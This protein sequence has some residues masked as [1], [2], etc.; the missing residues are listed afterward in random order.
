MKLFR[1]SILFL[2]LTLFAPKAF[3]YTVWNNTGSDTDFG[4]AANWSNGIPT[5]GVETF[6]LPGF[7]SDS[8]NLITSGGPTAITINSSSNQAVGILA[9]EGD[10]DGTTFG[11][12]TLNFT[13]GS[14]LTATSDIF[15]N[16][17][18]S[19]TFNGNLTAQ[20][21]LNEIGDSFGPGS[22]TLGTGLS[23][24]D[25]QTTSLVIGNAGTGSVTQTT[26]SI[27]YAGA[28]LTIGSGG[29]NGTYSV[30]NG[31]ILDLGTPGAPLSTLYNVSVG[32]STSTGTLIISGSSQIVGTNPG[33]SVNVGSK[34]TVTQSDTSVVTIG[35]DANANSSSLV[36][37][38]TYQLMGAAGTNAGGGTLNLNH[39]V[40]TVGG[41]NGLLSQTGNDSVL[42]VDAASTLTLGTNGKG[43]YTL[44]A[45]VAHF[46]GL[47]AIGGP[48]SS[49]TGVLNQSG[50][51]ALTAD[52]AVAIGGTVG[53]G[54]GIYTLGGTSATTATFSKG[55]T[56]AATGILNL[57]GGDLILGNTYSLKVNAG[58]TVNQ[59]AGTFSIDSTHTLNLTAAGSTYNLTGGIL[60]TS[61][62]GIVGT[63]GKLNFGG[64]TLQVVGT[65]FTDGV[66]G[67]LS[68]STPTLI[69]AS[70][71]TVTSVVMAGS[72]DG[73]GGIT[74]LGTDGTN[75][76]PNTAF[77]FGGTNSYTGPTTISSGTLNAASA[78]IQDS[79]ALNIGAAGTLNLNLTGGFTYDGNVAGTSSVTTGQFHVTFANTGDTFEIDGLNN[80]FLGTTTLTGGGIVEVSNGTF[81]AING[82]SSSLIIGDSGVAPSGVVNIGATSGITSTQ[83]NSQ[84][85][86][87]AVNLTGNVTN[88]G[89]L[90]VAN[91]IGGNVTNN[92]GSLFASGVGN[93][94][95]LNSGTLGSAAPLPMVKNTASFT[96]GGALNSS[97]TIIIR[98][99]GAVADEFTATTNSDVSGTFFK[100]VNASG[101][102]QYTIVDDTG[103]LTAT[104][105]TTNAPTSLF[106]ATVTKVGNTVVLN[107]TQLGL[108][109]FAV[110]PNQKAV[111]G[112]LDPLIQ[113]PAPNLAP[114]VATLNTLNPDQIASVLTLL[115][116]ESLQYARNISFENAT[117]LAEQ[118]SGHLANIRDGY[119]G[120]DTSGLSIRTV[121]L[122]SALGQSL[123]SLLAY[124]GPSFNR[125]APNGVNYYPQDEFGTPSS[126]SGGSI[127]DS[128]NPIMVPT[129]S[130]ANSSY[131]AQ[132]PSPS[133]FQGPYFSEF[134]AGNFIL[135]DLNQNQSSPNAAPSKASYTAGSATAGVSFRMTSNLAAGVLFDYNHT[136]A[137]TD[138]HGSKTTVNTYSPG[139]FAT[140]FEKGFYVD[141][142]FSFGYNNYKND[143]DVGALG[144]A[145]SSPSGEQYVTNV[146]FGYDFHPNPHWTF[147]PTLGMTYTHLDIDSFTETGVDPLNLSVASQSVDSLRSRLGGRVVYQVRS[148]TILF[149]PNFSAMWQHEY[150]NTNSGITSQFNGVGSSPFTIQTATNGKDSALLGCGVTA[151]LDNSLAFYLNYMADVGASDYYAQ[152]VEGGIKAQF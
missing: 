9:I 71:G 83:V 129:Q 29:G 42:N 73:T 43:T 2:T 49:D 13:N 1:G 26:G 47:L 12:V 79:S 93:D 124:N 54:S 48:G 11:S 105:I 120:L 152:T 138:D 134:I 5:A 3:A 21:T 146:N 25:S 10:I 77:S 78:D 107:T 87:N 58:G 57:A 72:L 122:D 92:T 82:S 61:T 88:A 23:N 121:G 144:T 110:T 46:H 28:T 38:G 14:T 131:T 96:V 65:S 150:L 109:N 114:L 90:N 20:G 4:T 128:P 70:N 39:T 18:D 112:A 41:S 132:R 139:L 45:G 36:I 24:W 94:I 31:A 64:G 32:N 17:G 136:D 76:T 81:G 69:D 151:V 16:G 101:T 74:F 98:M 68:G 62:A 108:G 133:V 53:S 111:A 22:M 141:G 84:F 100:L 86:L 37:A 147:G 8:S 145:H 33:V 125:P 85:T 149:Q 106:S 15:V 34:G 55:L 40:A 56:V 60:S 66:A 19:L 50:T 102:G 148:G 137:K 52:N 97:G 117:F 44:S 35:A 75:G 126:G 30:T 104:G 63:G 130:R 91:T 51:G 143:R 89:I 6:I 140:F 142:L 95:V 119:S 135:A 59:T 99:N 113:N 115:S 123:S 27:A 118:V 7:T 80:N 127:S 103:T 116:P 67:T